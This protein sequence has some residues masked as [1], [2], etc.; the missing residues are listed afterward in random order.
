VA[1]SVDEMAANRRQDAVGDFLRK[2]GAVRFRST[3][4]VSLA[5]TDGE[6]LGIV[7]PT[8]FNGYNNKPKGLHTWLAARLDDWRKLP[9]E[10][11]R[12]G[13]VQV[14]ELEN[15]DANVAALKPPK[16]ALILRVTNRT[17]QRGEQGQPRYLCADD[18]DKKLSEASCERYRDPSN[19]FM[20]VLQE[21]WRA[22]IPAE[23]K[24]GQSQPAPEA[25]KLR[26]YGH[27][28]NPNLG[29]QG[30]RAFSPS[31]VK[32]GTLT[33][34]VETVTDQSIR[35]RLDGS[36]LLDDAGGMETRL[37]YRPTVLGHLTYDRQKDAVIELELLAFGQLT[38]RLHRTPEE[39]FSEAPRLLGVA[40]ELIPN[41]KGAENLRPNAARMSGSEPLGGL[42]RYLNPRRS[43]MPN[44]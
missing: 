11:R 1:V 28:L 42:Q 37:V 20:W 33:L 27:H 21:E 9:E 35:L 32:E 2:S 17:M 40:F 39:L 7:N 19:D 44:D 24:V 6:T 3:G 43:G 31:S 38:G 13:A 22:M 29:I 23:P 4:Y 34:T 15:L 16:G 26:L 5:T 25:V 10:R 36:A 14:G 41:P 12:P 8:S 30:S 18:F